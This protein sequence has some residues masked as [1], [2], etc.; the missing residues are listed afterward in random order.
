MKWTLSMRYQRLLSAIGGGLL[1]AC[2]A[3][4]SFEIWGLFASDGLLP[5]V[6][7]SLEVLVYG[8][9][10]LLGALI[11]AVFARPIARQLQKWVIQI[12]AVMSRAPAGQLLS[13]IVGLIIGFVLAALGSQAIGS[14]A[15]R[16]VAT[17]LTVILYII[18]GS[19]G[20]TV[21]AKRYQEWSFDKILS[22][23]GRAAASF[24]PGSIAG[25][26]VALSATVVDTSALID[27]RI[28]G[29]CRAGFLS[30][31]LLIS[32]DVLTE[33]HH[34]ADDS[35]A[36]R[37]ARGR[38][39]LETLEQLK[40]E[41]DVR[42]VIDETAFPDVPEVDAR[43]VR[44]SLKQGARLFTTDYNQQTIASVAGVRVLRLNDLASALKPPL[45]VG[46]EVTLAISREGKER[47]QGVGYLEDGTMIVVEDARQL[48]GRTVTVIVTSALQTSSG[49]MIFARLKPSA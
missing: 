36:Q 31:T 14:L 16:S 44:L 9:F 26:A 3:V 32:S 12:S 22:R 28:L 17:A 8:G 18:L 45:A 42:V 19:V 37:R 48:V 15:P 2:I 25:N 23:A 49:R 46:D 10:C 5:P 1:G 34:I 30:G 40:A 13:A 4:L 7:A 21:G 47:A 41:P 27:G 38:R 11:G 29:V 33:L 39:G 24:A 43:L 6:I 20:G 35:D